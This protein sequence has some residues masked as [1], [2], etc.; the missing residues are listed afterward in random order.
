MS[1]Q[2][3]TPTEDALDQLTLALI[4]AYNGIQRAQV[5][6]SQRRI[7]NARSELAHAT[8]DI[9]RALFCPI[10]RAAGVSEG[11]EIIEETLPAQQ[12]IPL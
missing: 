1:D 9:A 4:G 11:L 2:D 7:G 10:A 5:E 12:E 3:R 8:D 6:L